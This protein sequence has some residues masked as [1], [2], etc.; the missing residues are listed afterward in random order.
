VTPP[1]GVGP[2]LGVSPPTE[3]S[4]PTIIGIAAA[5]M[6]TFASV[7][8]HYVVAQCPQSCRPSSGLGCF[9]PRCGPKCCAYWSRARQAAVSTRVDNSSMPS[10]S[11]RC[12][13]A[14]EEV[15][16]CA[17]LWPRRENVVGAAAAASA[18]APPMPRPG[19]EPPVVLVAL[20][21]DVRLSDLLR[22][23]EYHLVLGAEHAVLVDNSC[24]AP[25]AASRA[26]LAPYVAAGL[27]THHTQFVCVELRSMMFMHNF[28]GGS[29]MARQL[30]GLHSLPTGSLVVSLDD[31]EYLVLAEPE[32]TLRDLRRELAA[33]RVCALTL[34]W[35]VYGASGH[36]CQ[37]LGPLLRT[38]TQR[39]QTAREVEA[40]AI[41][42]A[43]R[44]ARLRHLN[45]PYGGKP[46][47]TYVAPTSPMCGTHWCDE[48]PAGLANC[49]LPE[50][51]GATCE[52]RY[53][54]TSDRFWINHYAFQSLQHWAAKKLRTPPPHATP[55]HARRTSPSPPPTTRVL[56][57]CPQADVPTSCL[58]ERVACP[59]LTS[60][61]S[62]HSPCNCSS[63]GLR[64]SSRRR[65]ARA[66]RRSL[67]TCRAPSQ[68]PPSRNNERHLRPRAPPAALPHRIATCDRRRCTRF[69]DAAHRHR[70]LIQLCSAVCVVAHCTAVGTRTR[71]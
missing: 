49:A 51:A 69:V 15:R 53:N 44:E 11:H 41:A 8:W 35:R 70:S 29:S 13:N 47:Y 2:G 32:H 55:Q 7:M 43:R 52:S 27:V 10:W 37:P 16:G 62:T 54:L 5:I 66:S 3:R 39:S 30:S 9:P 40:G 33:K 46:V 21:K 1:T 63:G 23:L 50:G 60:A 48:C 58:R 64:P 67:L 24:G 17:A 20:F 18:T 65:C 59:L 38:F 34:T 31:D 68:Q 36:R 57:P 6:V 14:P 22:F 26:A 25:A 19:A 45:T 12:P 4:L 42:A 56:R 28:R 71:H 61:Y